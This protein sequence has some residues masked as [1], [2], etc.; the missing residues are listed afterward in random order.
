MGEEKSAN[1]CKKWFDKP[2]LFET[3]ASMGEGFFWLPLLLKE[4]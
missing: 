1:V 4:G 2:F 3:F